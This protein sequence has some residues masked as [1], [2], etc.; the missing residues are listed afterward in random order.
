MERRTAYIYSSEIEKFNYGPDHPMK[1]K[2]IAM[3]HDILQQC[4]VLQNFDLYESFLPSKKEI[5]MFHSMEYIEFIENYFENKE[6]FQKVEKF[7]IGYS[8]DTPAFPDFFDFSRITSGSSLLSAELILQN[9]NDV[10]VNW[11]GGFHHAK[12]CRASGFCYFNDIVLGI[13]RLLT[14]FQKVT[15]NIRSCTLILMSITEMESKKPFMMTH[16]S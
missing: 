8:S 2:K 15:H 11:M 9:R 12:K 16:E 4:E 7:G 3:A 10:V 5:A 1:P 13:Q 14:R 6:E